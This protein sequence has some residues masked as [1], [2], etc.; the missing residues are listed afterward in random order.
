MRN[1]SV[2][3]IA[4]LG[5]VGCGGGGSSSSGSNAI[6]RIT[7]D[8]PANQVAVG[9]IGQAKVTIPAG[10]FGGPTT[11][12]VTERTAPRFN[13][14]DAKTLQPVLELEMPSVPTEDISIEYPDTNEPGVLFVASLDGNNPIGAYEI[15]RQNGKIVVTVKADT[16]DRGRSPSIFARL[17]FGV[18]TKISPP[19]TSTELV[20]VG[21]Q[22]GQGIVVFTHGIMQSS[23]NS[24][25]GAL[26]ALAVSGSQKAYVYKYDYRLSIVEAGQK[27]AQAI[28]SAGF[29]DKS[30]DLIGYSKGGLVNRVALETFGATKKVRRAIFLACPN[31]GCN[32]GISLLYGFYLGSF[33]VNPVGLPM[34]LIGDNSINELLPNSSALNNLNGYRH[35]Q[36]GL[37]DYYFFASDGDNVVYANSALAENFQIGNMTNG[38]VHRVTLHNSGHNAMDDPATITEVYAQIKQV[39]SGLSVTAEPEPN[40]P[41]YYGAW[42]TTVKIRNNSAQ[43]MT[44]E[45]VELEEFDRFGAWQGNYWYDES[46]PPG[47]FFP[48][49]RTSWNYQLSPGESKTLYIEYWPDESRTPV[50]NAPDRRKARSSHIIVLAH[51]SLGKSYRAEFISHMLYENYTLAEPLTRAPRGES[52]P[53]SITTWIK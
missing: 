35:V 37:V 23:D 31:S 42:Q 26:K 15:K 18:A 9:S 17:I 25:P 33:L 46:S 45:T 2:L 3:F 38:A 44:V 11:L 14:P 7:I 13:Q 6:N 16:F 52:A 20:Q 43:N 19:D 12:P 47:V 36:Q 21:S 34:V 8:V 39:E 48:H 24:Q 51:D 22:S 30:V 1:L 50:W 10:T 27:L 40:Y 53:S 41:S 29:A 49:Q 28:E 5:L 4:L 32:L